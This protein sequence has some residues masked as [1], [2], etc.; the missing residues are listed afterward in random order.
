M[1][2]RAAEAARACRVR[3]L[4]VITGWQLARAYLALRVRSVAV[5][6]N[7]TIVWCEDKSKS[8]GFYAE[9]FGL[10]APRPFSHFLVVELANGVELDFCDD[11]PDAN[12]TQHYAFLVSEAEFDTIFG[13]IQARG[14]PHW[15]D[16][17]KSQPGEINRRDGGR[18]VYFDDPDGNILEILTRPYGGWR[19]A[20]SKAPPDP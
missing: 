10:A 13:R 5:E 9:L 12:A 17:M 14:M 4:S 2:V 7:H 20:P 3:S 18:G 11:R 6:L 15:A 1:G 19:T 8:A 16:P